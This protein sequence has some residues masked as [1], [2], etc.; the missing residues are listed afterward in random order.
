M[1]AADGGTYQPNPFSHINP[2]HLA[3]FKFIG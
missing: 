2:D 3:H 1:A